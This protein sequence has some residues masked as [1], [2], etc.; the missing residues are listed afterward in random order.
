[1][2]IFHEGQIVYLTKHFHTFLK[3]KAPDIQI[4]VVGRIARIVKIIDWDTDE[5]RKIKAARESIEAWKDPQKSNMVEDYKYLLDILYPEI[6]YKGK[7]L[8]HPEVVPEYLSI[9]SK[10]RLFEPYPPKMLKYLLKKNIAPKIVLK[11][12]A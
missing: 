9:D 10:Q 1:M 2:G 12:D 3:A 4:Q 8:I 6:D 5:G 11:E 7:G